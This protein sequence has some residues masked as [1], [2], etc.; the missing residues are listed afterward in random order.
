MAY[1][2]IVT[3]SAEDDLAAIIEYIVKQLCNPD[4]A[5]KLLDE[6][7]KRYDVLE[8]NP[9]IYARCVHPLL[10]AGEYRKIVIGSY[11]LVFRVDEGNHT[12]FV[13]RIFNELQDYFDKL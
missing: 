2:L 4:A 8:E 13:N 6:I 7:D 11:L 5:V 1:K 12:V 9:Y 10:E 3:Q